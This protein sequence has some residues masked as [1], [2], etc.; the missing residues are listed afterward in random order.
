LCD[1]PPARSAIS[2]P[3][4][5]KKMM[6][7]FAPLLARIVRATTTPSSCNCYGRQVVPDGADHYDLPLV[8]VPAAMDM[9]GTKRVLLNGGTHGDEPAGVE[10]IVRFLEERRH[11][12]WPHVEFVVTPCA[13]P[14]G[15][16]HGRREGPDGL[17]LNRCFQRLSTAG[18]PCEPEREP[19]QPESRP[20]APAEVVH[21]Q[22]MLRSRPFDL[23]IDCHEDVDAPG[24]Y[25]FAPAGVGRTIVEAAGQA[26]PLHSGTAVDGE[27][28]LCESIV[29]LGAV[30]VLQVQSRHPAAGTLPLPLGSLAASLLLDG[31]HL[32]TVVTVETPARLPLAQRAAMQLSAIDAALSTL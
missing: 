21:L 15:Y 12:R 31:H 1:A 19:G 14:W 26:G 32:A 28:P 24:L 27:F 23:V 2:F 17:D 8:R 22:R 18:W 5:D 25:V 20:A 11:E 13:N 6:A 7:P 16:V 10:A 29:D 4:T 3:P 9:R 30:G